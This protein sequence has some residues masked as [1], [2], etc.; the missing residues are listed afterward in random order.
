MYNMFSLTKRN[1][2]FI[3]FMNLLFLFFISMPLQGEQEGQIYSASLKNDL[4]PE[5]AISKQDEIR[6]CFE[7]LSK[8]FICTSNE[9]DSL[10]EMVRVLNTTR[11]TYEALN[12]YV[13]GWNTTIEYQYRANVEALQ[14]GVSVSRTFII[15]DSI[16]SDKEMLDTLLDILETHKKD[17]IKVFYGLQREL[18]NE[19]DYHK[20][21]FLDVGLSDE[22]VFAKVTAVSIKGPQPFSVTITWDKNEIEK[23]NPFPYLKKSLYIHPFDEEAKKKLLKIAAKNSA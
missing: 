11:K 2:I 5:Y 19:P 17:G 10:H 12:H 16:L 18:K 1:G 20:Y 21:V 23:Q 7:S 13:Y 8:K 15:T 22:A 6:Q 3:V 14:R 9:E 4:L